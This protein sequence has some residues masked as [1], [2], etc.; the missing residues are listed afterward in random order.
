MASGAHEGLRPTTLVL[1]PRSSAL[2]RPSGELDLRDPV[3]RKAVAAT[4][5]P[6]ATMAALWGSG[7][8]GIA[9]SV[10]LGGAW[11]AA[12]HRR[13]ARLERAL[14]QLRGP[15]AFVRARARA[16]LEN[17]AAGGPLAVALGWVDDPTSDIE[18]MLAL[19]DLERGALDHALVRLRTHAAD[20]RRPRTR[21]AGRGAIGD[22]AR[23][24]LAW[25][26]PRCESYRVRRRS[27]YVATDWEGSAIP[28]DVALLLDVL[29]VLE[30]SD[31]TSV[32]RTYAELDRERLTQRF[33]L[34]HAL[35]VATVRRR[36]PGSG[37]A[38]SKLLGALDERPRAVAH[39]LHPWASRAS[40]DGY[41]RPSTSDPQ[42]QLALPTAPAH[43]EEVALAALGGTLGPA[44]PRAAELSN[45]AMAVAGSWGVAL[46]LFAELG[47]AGVPLFV[48]A[49]GLTGW[50]SLL[51]RSAR[52][53]K[54]APLRSLGFGRYA[55][56][57]E[58]TSRGSRS[59]RRGRHW[60]RAGYTML[61]SLRVAE[62]SLPRG[63]RAT[64]RG[65]LEWWFHELQP[66]TLQTLPMTGIAASLLRM[67]TLLGARE[68]RD[69][70]FRVLRPS[71]RDAQAGVLRTG[72]GDHVAALA[73][74]RALVH[75]DRS[76]MSQAQ[77]ELSRAAPYLDRIELD[78]DELDLYAE[79]VRRVHDAGRSL[80]Q[81]LQRWRARPPA[82][83]VEETWPAAVRAPAHASHGRVSTTVRVG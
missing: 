39:R 58:L 25:V 13:R 59:S 61:G 75:A 68:A 62:A 33:P 83:W 10:A 12:L 52:K 50:W 17:E 32:T 22:V 54:E 34:L 56:I 18:G 1:V 67:A 16:A 63:D 36:L 46:G 27:L 26:L 6:V 24:V 7:P 31:A 40:G 5:P 43:V 47:W 38:L 45:V 29:T 51:R 11:F 14:A 42:T 82:R 15:D 41:R 72:F 20:H 21:S 48:V 80:P 49:A 71:R 69:L 60:G 3:V 30:A 76:E 19:D 4:L 9:V 44:G 53:H 65:A 66:Q 73:L 77:H 70:L 8:A 78:E 79:L 23:A 55:R 28:P 74:A 57:A 35:V 37:G 81:P 64:A 2:P